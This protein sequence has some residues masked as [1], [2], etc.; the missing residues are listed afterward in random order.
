MPTY[1]A[2]GISARL[3]T[4]PLSDAI[5]PDVVIK[6][7]ET[8]RQQAEVAEQCL[9]KSKLLNERPVP[10]PG[11]N[12]GFEL[13][14]LGNAPFMQAQIT[15]P[16]T[17]FTNTKSSDGRHHLESERGPEALVL[18]VQLSDKAFTSGL[19]RK[20]S[21][22]VEV[23]FNGELSSCVFITTN[24]VRS[25]VKSLHQVFAGN[26]VDYLSERPWVI[27]HDILPIDDSSDVTVAPGELRWQAICEA[28]QCEA[29]ARGMDGKGNISSSAEFLTALASMEMPLQVCDMQWPGG[30]HFGVID[31]IISAGD[32]RKAINGGGYLKAPQRLKDVNFP[33][34]AMSTKVGE[35]VQKN[36]VGVSL[37]AAP[38]LTSDDDIDAEGESESDFEPRA[39][40]RAI[41]S[42]VL[43]S[44]EARATNNLV[45]GLQPYPLPPQTRSFPDSLLPT[46]INTRE[47]TD[48]YFPTV[49][50]LH[51]RQA[52]EP[53]EYR[54][55]VGKASNR[56]SRGSHGP[57][58]EQ[59]PR[60]LQQRLAD[61]GPRAAPPLPSSSWGFYN[62]SLMLRQPPY[63]KSESLLPF[64]FGYQSS[65]LQSFGH[66]LE[67]Q[68]PASSSSPF[69]PTA[70][71]AAFHGN[72]YDPQSQLSRGIRALAPP[73][74]MYPWLVSHAA[75]PNR[76]YAPDLPDRSLFV[77]SSSLNDS[78]GM[79]PV[80]HYTVPQKPKAITCIS[81]IQNTSNRSHQ[82][83][84]IH[85]LVVYGQN[86]P[87]IDHRWPTPRRV[88]CRIPKGRHSRDTLSGANK[89]GDDQSRA[90]YLSKSGLVL[91]GNV[92]QLDQAVGTSE[93]QSSARIVPS[94]PEKYHASGILGIQ[95]PKAAT[96]WFDNPEEMLRRPSKQRQSIS[97][98]KQDDRGLAMASHAKVASSQSSL[99]AGTI[100][101]SPLS[102]APTTPEL[103]PGI[104]LPQRSDR[105]GP[106]IP[107]TDGPRDSIADPNAFLSSSMPSPLEKS[108][109][110]APQQMVS[111]TTAKTATSATSMSKKRKRKA[112]TKSITEKWH[113]HKRIVGATD[114]PLSDNC[115]ITFADSETARASPGPLRQV[116]SERQGVFKED[117]VVFAARFF[118]PGN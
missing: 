117:Y 111:K 77:P 26:R 49:H 42:R 66:N 91:P 79:P 113:S 10:F 45:L 70:D 100:S 115:V 52:S 28:L 60:R 18:H 104:A 107:Q 80:G 39:K 81:K 53:P 114:S 102:S 82:S 116:K 14:W 16:S 48:P 15:Q 20:T 19:V 11:D 118:V 63:S 24:D 21:L 108:F 36:R 13:N 8:A 67:E 68:F 71:T 27:K 72:R 74:P 61:P 89:K 2:R 38:D 30:R 109:S 50:S 56:G 23:F 35:S 6:K 76:V 112:R 83:I 31:V 86:G 75:H 37:L 88:S 85:R 103:V 58:T 78:R 25:G 98:T 105:C 110:T 59:Q 51:H 106:I 41:A 57:I 97:P 90:A 101:S 84:L 33:L 96:F 22:K 43:L 9:R 65:S 1:H 44:D 69:V 99:L 87:I 17:H 7:G 34:R 73:A 40:K 64:A 5:T 47:N 4:L 92:E 54:Y 46:A 62:D 12:D 95:D 94:G 93:V 32:G 29:Q 3:G 55:K